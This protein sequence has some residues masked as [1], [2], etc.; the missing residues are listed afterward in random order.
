MRR[1]FSVPPAG[2]EEPG[3]YF[4]RLGVHRCA[5]VMGQ[6]HGGRRGVWAPD[7]RVPCGRVISVRPRSRDPSCRGIRDPRAH[8]SD[9]TGRNEDTDAHRGAP[10][11]GHGAD[12]RPHATR[13]ASGG[14]RLPQ[15]G[16]RRPASRTLAEDIW[17]VA[18]SPGPLWWQK[19]TAV[20]T[21]AHD[22]NRCVKPHAFRSVPATVSD[23]QS[24]SLRAQS[25]HCLPLLFTPVFSAFGALSGKP[26]PPRTSVCCSPPTSVRNERV[27]LLLLLLCC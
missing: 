7:G 3:E 5:W 22:G 6:G 9:L 15:P 13:E 14:A 21:H 1:G 26:A 2:R 8:S 25:T 12:G 20:L 24:G 16:L 4:C 23:V 18:P 11:R 27:L 17:C 10:T 19:P